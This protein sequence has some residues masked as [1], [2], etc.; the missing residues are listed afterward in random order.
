[1]H[2]IMFFSSIDFDF[3]QCL[4]GQNFYIFYM[5]YIFFKFF[6]FNIHYSICFVILTKP[7]TNQI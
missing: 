2:V 3:N 4:L 6:M 7:H 5:Y 1:M